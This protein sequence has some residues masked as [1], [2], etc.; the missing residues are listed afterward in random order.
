MKDTWFYLPESKHTRLVSIQ[1]KENNAWKR[2][3]IT[4]YNPDYPLKGAKR[5]FSGGAGLSSTAKDYATFLQMYLNNG[6]LNGLR[7]LSRTTI[8]F[9]MANQIGDLMGASGTHYGLAFAVL[10]QKGQN[11]GGRGS[12]GTF[13][14]GGYFNTQYFAD[15]KEQIIGILMKQTQE[16]KSDNT[17][18]KFRQLVGQAIDD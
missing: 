15:P 2:Y 13:D 4:F 3:P 10:D 9:M 5:F 8:Q 18:W 1:K 7:Y 16:T 14:W 11:M 6:E 12:S 17:D